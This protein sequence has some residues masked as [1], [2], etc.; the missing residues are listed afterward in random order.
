MQKELVL[1]F[2]KGKI[3][4]C[5]IG[6]HTLT[7]MQWLSQCLP[8]PKSPGF[9]NCCSLPGTPRR[10]SVTM[11]PFSWVPSSPYLTLPSWELR[12]GDQSPR[13]GVGPD[14]GLA[15]G[16]YLFLWPF[17]VS[18]SVPPMSAVGAQPSGESKRWS[19]REPVIPSGGAP[20]R[21]SRGSFTPAKSS[22][23]SSGSRGRHGWNLSGTA[24]NV[25]ET[26]SQE[27]KHHTQRV[28]KLRFIIPAGPRSYHSKLWAPNKWVTEFLYTDKRD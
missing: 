28:G 10:L 20:A 22:H 25:A 12:G 1:Q 2:P 18:W 17:L 8:S 16:P 9:L 4:L 5:S 14:W 3:S 24:R 19:K 11:P 27:T 26:S 23:Q 15:L 21:S 13:L 6:N 7:I